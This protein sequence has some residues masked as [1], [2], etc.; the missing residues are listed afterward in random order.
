M[1][2]RGRHL[3]T[4]NLTISAKYTADAATQEEYQQVYSSPAAGVFEFEFRPVET[5]ASEVEFLLEDTAADVT[6][7]EVTGVAVEVTNAKP[8]HR[9]RVNRT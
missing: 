4:D 6:G 5:R 2:V 8:G 7:G 3:D 9:T 1:H